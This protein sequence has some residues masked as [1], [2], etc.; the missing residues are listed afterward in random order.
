MISR[1]VRLGRRDTVVRREALAQGS[2]F[3]LMVFLGNLFWL[4]QDLK[5]CKTPFVCLMKSALELTIFFL[6]QD[7]IRSVLGQSQVSFR[8]LSSYIIGETEPKIL[9]LVLGRIY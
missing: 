7:S 2:I 3:F 1:L 9:R 4:R 5:K 8:P 6:S